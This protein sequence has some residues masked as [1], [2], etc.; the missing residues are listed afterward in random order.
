M[1]H[2]YIMACDIRTFRLVFLEYAGLT[3]NQRTCD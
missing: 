1:K 2:S 3:G